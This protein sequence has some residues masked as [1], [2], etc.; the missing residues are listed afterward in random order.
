M[1]SAD[2][3]NIIYADLPEVN[4]R[5]GCIDCC[6]VALW[7]KTEW[8]AVPA[9]KK[10]NIGAVTVPM[11]GPGN[12][13]LTA[14]LPVQD[15]QIM[16]LAMAKKMAV[17][18]VVAEGLLLA[19]HGLDGIL[20]PFAIAGEGCGVYANRPFI[21]RVMGT[22]SSPSRLRC[23]DGIDPVRPLPESIVMQLFL[24]WTNLLETDLRYTEKK[25]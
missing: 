2:I 7:S 20:C 15:H 19:S 22:A 10:D 4:C 16:A 18:E 6:T 21:C 9:E 25:P 24:L 1:D 17:V 8:D 14:L 23:P 3:L 11:R 5:P 12:T 13:R